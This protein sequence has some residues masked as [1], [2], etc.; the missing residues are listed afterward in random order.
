MTRWSTWKAHVS[1]LSLLSS[2]INPW[3]KKFQPLWIWSNPEL[4]IFSISTMSYELWLP[5][6]ETKLL[7]PEKVTP[8]FFKIRVEQARSF[9]FIGSLYISMNWDGNDYIIW[10]IIIPSKPFFYPKFASWTWRVLFTL[11][12]RYSLRLPLILLGFAVL[13]NR[14]T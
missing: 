11:W 14:W 2:S 5:N 3:T 1:F 8:Q 10:Y 13:V 4:S 7:W 6:H 9:F 12:I